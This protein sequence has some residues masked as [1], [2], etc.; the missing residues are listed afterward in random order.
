LS[1]READFI[2]KNGKSGVPGGF[3][4]ITSAQTSTFIMAYWNQILTAARG[5]GLSLEGATSLLNEI[6]T[7][8][9]RM[10][11]EA[12]QQCFSRLEEA[13]VRKMPDLADPRVK[14]VILKA[15]DMYWSF[16]VERDEASEIMF[17]PTIPTKELI[18]ESVNE[19]PREGHSAENA[20]FIDPTPRDQ[21]IGYAFCILLCPIHA[22]IALENVA[23]T[24]GE[25]KDY[26]D[27]MTDAKFQ[28]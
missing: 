27:K 24:L 22:G 26:L 13:R 17:V 3:M 4:D 25:I 14:G 16:K 8:L 10:P 6:R 2:V 12:I 19:E 20:P 9:E 11:E 28:E 1:A 7:L 5:A 21:I 15:G 18:E 23:P